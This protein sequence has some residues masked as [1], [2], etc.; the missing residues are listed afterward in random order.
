[1]KTN[2]NNKDVLWGVSNPYT[3]NSLAMLMKTNR[4]KKDV[5]WG[6]TILTLRIVLAMLMKTN[7]NNKDVLWG[8]SNPYTQNSPGYANE[9]EQKQQRRF[10]GR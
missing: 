9:D 10:M 8:G 7:R 5:L 3:Q 1:M 4:N 2:R 6:D